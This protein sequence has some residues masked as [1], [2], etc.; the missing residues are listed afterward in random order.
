LLPLLAMPTI[1]DRLSE[2]GISWAWYAEGWNDA[3]VG[4]P[5]PLFQFHHQPFN[6]FARYADGT[7]ARAEHLK[8]VQ[9]FFAALRANNL[10]A[11]AFVKSQMTPA[12]KAV[13]MPP[14]YGFG[15]KFGP[16]QVH[17][18]ALGYYSGRVPDLIITTE[19]FNGEPILAAGLP[20]S[21][22]LSAPLPRTQI[23]SSP[24]RPCFRTRFLSSRSRKPQ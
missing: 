21:V 19:A 24:S 12:V 4:R 11:V 15:L 1:G 6:Y 8:D 22:K 23:A 16:P 5:D 7:A 13:Y 10:P 3:V 20:S 18:Y 2:K 9:D 17:D 14:E